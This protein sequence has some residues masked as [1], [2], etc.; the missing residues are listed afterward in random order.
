MTDQRKRTTRN[1]RLLLAGLLLAGVLLFIAVGAAKTDG[2]RVDVLVNGK[3][4]ES[5]PLNTDREIK[6]NYSGHNLLRIEDGRARIV[7]ADCPDKLCMKQGSIAKT[8]E[9]IVCL[10]HRVVIR[11]SGGEAPAVDGI[12]R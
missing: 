11:I 10:P 2:A 12:T 7:G 3:V 9:T 6:L 1:D 4:A 5:Y 8:G